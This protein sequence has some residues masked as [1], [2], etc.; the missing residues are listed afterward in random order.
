[1]Q[2][3]SKQMQ[4]VLHRLFIKYKF[5]ET[6]ARSLAKIYTESTLDGVSSHGINRVPLFIK[7]EEDGVVIVE[8]GDSG[9]A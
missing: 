3:P 2:I 4:G 6:Q 1:M 5:P 8:H 7:Y 9:P